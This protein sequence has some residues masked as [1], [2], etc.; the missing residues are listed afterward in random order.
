M[1]RKLTRRELIAGTAQIGVGLAASRA[2]SAQDD[3]GGGPRPPFRLSLNSSTLGT[4][5]VEEKVR[6]AAEAGYGG[7]EL[8]INEL[9]DHAKSG[10]PLED[11]GKRIEDAGLRVPNVIG[12]WNCMP[13]EDGQRQAALTE[14]RRKIEQAQKVRA[15]HIAAIC[16]PDRPDID[17]LWAA[18]RYREIMGIGEEYG[19]IPGV[20]FVGFFRGIRTLGQAAAIAI[21]SNDPRACIVA[22]TFHLYRGGSGFKGVR[23]LRGAAIAVC[24]FNDAPA[25]PPQ[26]EQRDADRVYPGDGILPLVEFVRDLRD[27]GFSGWLSLELFNR[28]YFAKPPLD[29]ARTGLAKMKQIVAA[30]EAAGQ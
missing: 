28:D 5:G 16:T 1:S 3:A 24:H 17:V 20:E 29:N 19:I 6:V 12:L 4:L 22:D 8:W 10:K 2:V 14:V 7:I 18:E 21:H 23:L 9:D 11:L 26:F 13:A 27:I 30:S 25:A 15:E